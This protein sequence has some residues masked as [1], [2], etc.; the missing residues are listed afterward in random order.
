MYV[1]VATRRIKP[2]RSHGKSNTLLF[3]LELIKRAEELHVTYM[4][5]CN[6]TDMY[7]CYINFRGVT[8]AMVA[9]KPEPAY[10]FHTQIIRLCVKR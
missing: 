5:F 8:T 3:E 7:M 10:Y 1:T 9:Q 2:L 4:D 6:T